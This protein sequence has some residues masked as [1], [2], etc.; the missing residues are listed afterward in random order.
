MEEVKFRVWDEYNKKWIYFS[1]ET[2]F[3][4][5]LNKKK[6]PEIVELWHARNYELRIY[7]YTGLKDKDNKEIYEGDLIR[8]ESGR[9]C[10]VKWCQS[11]GQWDAFV[12][13]IVENDNASGFSPE[14]WQY[15]VKKIG[16]IYENSELLKEC[17][18][19]ST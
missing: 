19:A 14:V 7:R 17:N 10:E 18:N 1:V 6:R 15:S 3:S 8:N 4:D 5:L 16:D 2:L 12:K 13:I 11:Y 9:V